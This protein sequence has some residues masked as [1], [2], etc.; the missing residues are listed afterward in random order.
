[1]SKR[2]IELFHNCMIVKF[3]VVILKSKAQ[4]CRD[5]HLSTKGLESTHG[6]RGSRRAGSWSCDRA[7]CWT[8]RGHTCTAGWSWWWG[9]SPQT[10]SPSRAAGWT[11]SSGRPGEPWLAPRCTLWPTYGRRWGDGEQDGRTGSPT[12]RLTEPLTTVDP[13]TSRVY[14]VLQPR[15][16]TWRQTVEE[17]WHKKLLDMLSSMHWGFSFSAVP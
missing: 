10:Q 3:N 14:T 6:S 12:W 1:M 13:F 2:Q 7:A 11:G 4:E 9:R 8:A 16:Q 15:P 5:I 17:T